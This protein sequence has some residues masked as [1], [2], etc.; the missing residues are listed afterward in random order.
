M[1]LRGA[2]KCHEQ[3]QSRGKLAALQHPV[4]TLSTALPETEV[5]TGAALTSPAAAATSSHCRTGLSS[6]RPLGVL[7]CGTILLVLAMP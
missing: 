7:C 3:E 6:P 5:G 4:L 1:P 2:G